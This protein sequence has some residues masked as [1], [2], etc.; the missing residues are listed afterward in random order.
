MSTTTYRPAGMS[1]MDRMNVPTTC[2]C[3]DRQGLKT[4]VKLVG[5]AGEIVWMG[6]GCAAKAMG[7]GVDVFRRA[8]READTVLASAEAAAAKVVSDAEC[9]RWFAWLTFHA[10]PGD[11]IVQIGRLGGYAA[12]RAAYRAA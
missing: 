11:V 9:A 1:F 5:P 2:G 4:T 10:G 8:A 7:V 6:T 3:C 12:A